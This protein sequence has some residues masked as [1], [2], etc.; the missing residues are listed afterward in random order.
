M[1]KSMTGFGRG[2]YDLNNCKV[3]IEIKSVNHRYCDVNCR[4]PRK[5]SFIENDIIAHIKKVVAR[6]KID[7]FLTYE[8]NSDEQG[9]IHYNAQLAKEYMNHFDVISTSF[10]I[11]NDIKVSHLSR[12]PEVI[13]LKE[14]DADENVLKELILGAVDIAVGKLSEA[15]KIEGMHLE[16]DILEKLQNMEKSLAVIN[17]VSP[18]VVEKYK[19]K[20]HDRMQELLEHGEVDEARLALEVTLYT[21]KSCID[22]EIVR[23]QSHIEHMRK[24]LKVK[25]PVGRKMDFL[26]QEMNREANTILSKTNGIKIVS[27][28]LDLK[29][30]IEKIREQIQNIE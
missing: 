22:E 5:L 29:S 18:Q 26:A 4:L 24:L 9:N 19:E 6:G 25:E 12:Y 16:K 23:L 13:Q 15:R 8:D 1:V 7:V 27:E 3:T 28:G 17:E 2:D 21:D 20:L 30:E 10:N 11:E 14:K